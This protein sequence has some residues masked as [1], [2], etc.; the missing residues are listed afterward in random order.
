MDKEADNAPAATD[1]KPLAVGLRSLPRF[2]L[3]K[4]IIGDI[5]CWAVMADSAAADHPVAKVST[6][7]GHP[8]PSRLVSSQA[9]AQGVVLDA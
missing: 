2:I 7:S 1:A 6:V 3:R 8:G 4:V 9:V 5:P